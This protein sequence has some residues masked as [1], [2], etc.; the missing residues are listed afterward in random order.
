[1]IVLLV[2]CGIAVA[3]LLLVTASPS[4]RRLRALTQD[5]QGGGAGVGQ[6]AG[7]GRGRRGTRAAASAHG[8]LASRRGGADADP[9]R[10][11]AVIDRAA[12]LLRI[13]MPPATVTMQLAEVSDADLAVVLTR[14]SR[15]MSMGDDPQTAIGR[16]VAELPGALA[17]VLTGM[18]AVWAVAESAGAP[19][20]DVLERYAH[21]RREIAE[22]ERERLVALAGP[23]AT[24]T[25]LTWLPA[26]GLGLA[27]L[28]GADPRT[29]L[30]SP[31]GLASIGSGVILLLCGRVW[32]T[33]MLEAAS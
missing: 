26:A 21:S 31:V 14:V 16:H 12:A 30:G 17:D 1:M 29:L 27:L 11:I 7:V 10:A 13:G 23:Q 8:G 19:A 22:A 32:M 6:G 18:G 20:A 33:R 9:H 4:G 2:A 24:V 15:S 3:G 25:V 5:G 28:I